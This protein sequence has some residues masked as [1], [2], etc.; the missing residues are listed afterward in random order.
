M[1]PGD[2]VKVSTDMRDSMCGKLGILVEEADSVPVDSSFSVF[3]EDDGGMYIERY[4]HVYVSGACYM[5]GNF[6]LVLISTKDQ[7]V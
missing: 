7:D 5:Y 2:L 1:K 3:S 6:E 4:F